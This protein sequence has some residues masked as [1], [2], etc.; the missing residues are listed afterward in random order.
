MNRAEFLTHST[1][2]YSKPTMIMIKQYELKV[3]NNKKAIRASA[4]IK[5]KAK[6]IEN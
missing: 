6:D 1:N 5:K 4:S 3:F 2:I